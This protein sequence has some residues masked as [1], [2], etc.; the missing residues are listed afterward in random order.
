MASGYINSAETLRNL[1]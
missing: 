1:L